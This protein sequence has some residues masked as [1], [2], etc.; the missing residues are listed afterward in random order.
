MA[1]SPFSNLS[2]PKHLNHTRG[3]E[4]AR[5]TRLTLV[6]F[7]QKELSFYIISGPPKEIQNL[8]FSGSVMWEKWTSK[9]GKLSFAN[10]TFGCFSS[11]LWL[12]KV[13]KNL[14][15]RRSVIWENLSPI[16]SLSGCYYTEYIYIYIQ[17]I[18]CTWVSFLIWWNHHLQRQ[19]LMIFLSFV[20]Y[21]EPELQQFEDRS[22]FV[23]ISATRAPVAKPRWKGEDSM[24]E[25]KPKLQLMIVPELLQ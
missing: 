2:S 1:F 24:P 18:E 22:I 8:A 12:P 14:S 20:A 16:F 4:F 15:I 6:F 25:L 13:D 21:L 11:L 5:E 10:E 19:I 9:T 7:S 23:G 17:S 3:G